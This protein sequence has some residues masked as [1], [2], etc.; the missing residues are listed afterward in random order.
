MEFH[1]VPENLEEMREVA[2]DLELELEEETLD[3]SDGYSERW[4][5][6]VADVDEDEV[7]AAEERG[8]TRFAAGDDDDDEDEGEKARKTQ[9]TGRTAG[10]AADCRLSAA[11]E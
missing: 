9:R 4:I 2:G 7:V 8:E 5:P 11:P 1:P 3:S 6:K 10:R